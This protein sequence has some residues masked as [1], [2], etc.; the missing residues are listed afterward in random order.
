M[1]APIWLA[2]PP[3]VHSSL[4]S[5]GP[6]PGS[7]LAAAAAWSAL[8]AEYASAAIELG[9]VAGDVEVGVWQGPSADQYVT[10]NAPYLSWLL[11]SA[12]K[13]AAAAATHETAAAAYSV[14]LA[15]MP[16]MA[17]LT[18]NHAV[19]TALLVTNFFGINTIPIA[20]NE[21]DYARMWIQAAETM[22]VYQSVSGAALAALPVTTPAPQIL[23]AAAE[24]TVPATTAVSAAAEAPAADSGAHLNAADA[25]STE[26]Q[27]ASATDSGSSGLQQLDDFLNNFQLQ[28]AQVIQQYTNNFASPVSFDL[29]PNGFPIDRFAF[30]N[31]LKALLTQSFP[32]LNPTLVTT[33]SWATFHTAMVIWPIAQSTLELSVVGA[34]VAAGPAAAVAA[35]AGGTA[36]ALGIV[37]VAV[38]HPVDVPVAMP[39]PA[40]AAPAPAISATT[41]SPTVPSTAAPG[42]SHASSVSSPAPTSPAPT[43]TPPGGGPSVGAGPTTSIYAVSAAR[44]SAQSQV[45]SRRSR[46]A[47][48]AAPAE[49]VG[50]E[51]AAAAT[52]AKKARARRRRGGTVQDRSY[53]YE[54][55]EADAA[56]VLRPEDIT[57]ASERGADVR[58]GISAKGVEPM[59]MTTRSGGL[60]AAGTAVPL[61]PS[62]W[63]SDPGRT[64]QT[65]TAA[66]R[67]E[68]STLEGN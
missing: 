5:S 25:A 31:G 51:A 7:L 34:I 55:L 38:P 17:E 20:V 41:V 13:S 8:S 57:R 2:I 63:R 60:F 65:G 16:S 64:D 9:A 59:G 28:L 10:A 32:F 11:N 35:A 27:A 23:A 4:L 12:E 21:A 44:S 58:G 14:A 36:T 33:L 61:L 50:E 66:V 1:T 52:A 68:S 46:N 15:A 29:N 42:L 47:R 62:N 40:V 45:T 49:A 43:G 56:P 26:Q 18:I 6:G 24:A 67:D 48:E 30:V 37:G 54:Y 19:H 53:R 3:E 22:T 39:S